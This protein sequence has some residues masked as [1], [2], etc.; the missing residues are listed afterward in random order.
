MGEIEK[1]ET[2]K[3]FTILD[4]WFHF[5]VFINIIIVLILLWYG[6]SA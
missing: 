6:L 5:G 1:K 2:Q 3:R 4:Y